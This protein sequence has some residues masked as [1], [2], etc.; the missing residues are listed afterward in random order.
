M[1]IV[2][3]ANTTPMPID[4]IAFESTVY[5]GDVS[6]SAPNTVISSLSD[7]N[8]DCSCESCDYQNVVFAELT[9]TNPLFNDRT[10]F[11][12][13]AISNSSTVDFYL[14]KNDSDI[15]HIV[16]NTYGAL[17]SVGG[18]STQLSLSTFMVDWQKILVNFGEGVYTMRVETKDAS[19]ATVNNY[20]PDYYL[21]VYKAKRAN[22][23]VVFNWF[24][25]GKILDNP[26]DFTGLNIEQYVRVRGM[27]G[28]GKPKI[29][30]DEIE[31][32]NH[33]FIQ[34]QTKVILDYTFESEEL[35]NFNLLTLIKDAFVASELIITDYNYYNSFVINAL[36]MV[37]QE[38][39][40]EPFKLTKLAKLTA[41]L[42][43]KTRATIKRNY[44]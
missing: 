3:F 8:N 7:C 18:Y 31:L 15:V 20:S 44:F 9:I 38:C 6:A 26:I 22:S 27:V 41:R 34:V 1:I 29:E 36:P 32:S 40:V 35:N 23:T 43:E 10:Q 21:Q 42:Q 16:D 30:N 14:Q 28:W 5:V 2:D 25:N 17:V 12:G 39:S 13:I 11:F 33:E 19:G 24:Q 37:V 4:G